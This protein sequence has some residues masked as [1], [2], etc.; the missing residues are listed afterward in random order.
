MRIGF[1]AEDVAAAFP[2]IAVGGDDSAVKGYDLPALVA[3]LVS[4]VQRLEERL[5]AVEAALS[6]KRD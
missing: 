1:V 6:S 2:E 3:I 5:D 4:A